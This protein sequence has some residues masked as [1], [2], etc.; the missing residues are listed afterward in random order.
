MKTIIF[1]TATLSI[2]LFLSCGYEPVSQIQKNYDLNEILSDSNW[3]EITDTVDVT[4]QIKCL[5]RTFINWGNVLQ[6]ENDYLELWN[7]SLIEIK[8]NN[9]NMV[10]IINCENNVI[11][12]SSKFKYN[13]PTIDFSNRT[14]LGFYVSTGRAYFL[15][16][17]FINNQSKELFYSLIIQ[18]KSGELILIGYLQWTSIPKIALDYNFMFDTNYAKIY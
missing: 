4:N 14:V 13:K 5:S 2:I 3:I 6:Y 11:Y 15:R 7:K 18:P 16:R 17:I 12:D 8:E 1:I 10:H 9:F